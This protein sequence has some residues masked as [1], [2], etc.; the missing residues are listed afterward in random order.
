[1]GVKRS[2][3]RELGWWRKASHSTGNG[4]CIEVASCSGGLAVRDSQDPTGPVV[5][6]TPPDWR[7]F[8]TEVRSDGLKPL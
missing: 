8:I 3:L 7:A 2:P 1:M 5:I 4:A 6:C